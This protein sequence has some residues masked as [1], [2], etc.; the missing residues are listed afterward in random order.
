MQTGAVYYTDRNYVF[1]QL[2]DELSNLNGI[3]TPN[4]DKGSTCVAAG[5]GPPSFSSGA[6]AAGVVNDPEY[7]CFDVDQQARVY[8][9][10]DQRAHK[11]AVAAA[12]KSGASPDSVDVRL[13]Y[14]TWLRDTTVWADTE[15]DFISS[16]DSGGAEFEVFSQEVAKGTVCIGGNNDWIADSTD[17]TKRAWPLNAM[18]N[19]IV[20]VG[21]PDV[22]DIYPT[23]PPTQP[24]SSTAS[25]GIFGPSGGSRSAV[26]I[27][28][29]AIVT[30]LV[31]VIAVLAVVAI[32]AIVA[33]V[34]KKPIAQWA[35]LQT[36]RFS[37]GSSTAGGGSSSSSDE[38]G[39]MSAY[40]APLFSDEVSGGM[41]NPA[42]G[43]DVEGSSDTAFHAMEDG[44]VL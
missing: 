21:P 2:P 28:V 16:T 12:V 43:L 39:N 34:F 20:L 32:I 42:H 25:G 44:D 24:S 30:A 22:D 10:Y 9:L 27:I 11:N 33:V 26:G 37:F 36:S 40:E 18:C 4:D 13:G 17:P 3:A 29:G 31:V 35:K 1:G 6:C 8:V 19:Y 15:I 23:L 5:D 14:P 7:L 38:L 41:M